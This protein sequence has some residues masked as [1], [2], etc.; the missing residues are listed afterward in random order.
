MYRADKIDAVTMR[1]LTLATKTQQ[2]DWLALVDCPEKHAPTGTTLKA[3]LFGGSAL[4]A[5][6]AMFGLADYAGEV[7]SDLFGE[8]SYFACADTFRTTQMAEVEKRANS[9]REPGLANIVLLETGA[10][11]TS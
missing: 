4:A 7:I 10:G 9:L 6:V 5:K 8:D 11:F 2:R 3:W 1:H